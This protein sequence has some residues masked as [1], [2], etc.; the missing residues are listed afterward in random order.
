MPS[1]WTFLIALHGDA[2]W[3]MD[4]FV[5]DGFGC[6]APTTLVKSS[7]QRTETQVDADSTREPAP[8]CG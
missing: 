2:K 6:F 7:E 5:D 1:P 4:T 3:S 8:L